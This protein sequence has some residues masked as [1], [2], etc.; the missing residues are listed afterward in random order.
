[1][2]DVTDP[3]R[4]G[5]LNVIV[6]FVDIL[7]FRSMVEKLPAHEIL[8]VIRSLHWASNATSEDPDPSAQVRVFSDSVVRIARE[9]EPGALFSELNILRQAQMEMAAQGVFLRGGITLGEVYWDETIIFGPAL[10]DAYDIES[11]FAIVPRIVVGPSVLRAIK[12]GQIISL[13]DLDEELAYIRRILS[14]AEDGVWF[15]D[16]LLGADQE[17]D[18]PEMYCDL[19]DRHKRA[20]LAVSSTSDRTGR[21]SSLVMKIGWLARYHNEKVNEISD[22]YLTTMG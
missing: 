14:Q 8:R 15:I 17:M 2:D 9:D 18:E 7:G 3:S 13:H 6:A 5:Y 20:I 22:S 4:Q 21:L 11:H 19:L 1:M 12:K 10:V 16:Y